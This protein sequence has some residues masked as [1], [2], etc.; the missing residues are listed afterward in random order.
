MCDRRC[1]TIL[2]IA[3]LSTLVVGC[4]QDR[5]TYK[6]TELLPVSLSVVDTR[7][8]EVIW[9]RDIPVRHKMVVDFDGAVDILGVYTDKRPAKKMT[10]KLLDID[11]DQKIETGIVDLD[12]TIP[13]LKVDYR[14]APEFAGDLLQPRPAPAEPLIALPPAQTQPQVQ[15]SGNG[16]GGGP[17][18]ALPAQKLDTPA[19]QSEDRPV[20][21]G[22]DEE[23]LEPEEPAMAPEPAPQPLRVPSESP[24]PLAFPQD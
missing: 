5:F 10:W 7:S 21:R 16:G 23:I 17:V 18:E 15:S 24:D 4:S 11:T 2:L 1:S 9:S 3:I 22:E 13:M 6:S 14:Q 8:D 19:L 20:R 12:S